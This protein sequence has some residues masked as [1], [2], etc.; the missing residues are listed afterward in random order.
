[1]DISMILK[2]NEIKGKFEQNHPK[3]IQFLDAVQ[4]R[5]VPEGTLLEMTVEYPDGSRATTNLRVKKEDLELLELLKTL[6]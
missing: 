1:M 2:M 5:G 4:R 3:V 6:R